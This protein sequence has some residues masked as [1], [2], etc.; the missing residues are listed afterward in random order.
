MESAPW[1]VPPG[2]TQS[3]EVIPPLS[4]TDDTRTW[5]GHS[6]VSESPKY[7][8]QVELPDMFLS[9]LFQP[10]EEGAL[11]DEALTDFSGSAS[12]GSDSGESPEAFQEFMLG[13][14]SDSSSPSLDTSDGP[15]MLSSPPEDVPAFKANASL[16]GMFGAWAA[17]GAGAGAAPAASD[18]P[19]APT[20]SMDHLFA[21]IFSLG[22]S[23]APL[24]PRSESSASAP[25]PSPAPQPTPEAAPTSAT[26]AAPSADLPALGMLQMPTGSN[27]NAHS[28]L[29]RIREFAKQVD[30]DTAPADRS[31]PRAG[32]TPRASASSAAESSAATS[33][34]SD[35]SAWSK[36]VAHNAI[37]RRYRSN[38]NDRIAGLRDVVPALREMRPRDGTRRRRRNK[39]EKQE[40]VDGVAAAT[41]MSKATVL[42][43]ATEYICYLKSRE[44]QL[45]RQVSALQMLVRSLEG[46]DELLAAWNAELARVDRLHPPAEAA[47]L[48]ARPSTASPADDEDEE[49]DEEDE[50]A[51]DGPR[52][53]M[54]RYLLGAFVGFSVVN[55]AA[56]WAAQE[57]PALAPSHTRVLHAGH[58]LLKRAGAAAPAPHTYDHVPTVHLV[59]ELLR[60]LALVALV[61]V[62]LC[63]AVVR[64]HRAAKH[65]RLKRAER[66]QEVCALPTLLQT[67][68]E[69][70]CAASAEPLDDARARYAALSRA[71]PAFDVRVPFVR[72]V[73]RGLVACALAHVPLLDR[74]VAWAI[75]HASDPT[76]QRLEKHVCL[77]RLTL[78]LALGRA[79]QPSNLQRLLTLATWQKHLLAAPH[80]D[81][82][83][84]LLAL[85]YA[86]LAP[87]SLLR[88]WLAYQ[89]AQLWNEARAVHVDAGAVRA[90]DR[91][92]AHAVLG[93]VLRLPLDVA[94][95]YALSHP[96]ART[97]ELTSVTEADTR[98]AWVCAAPLRN[99]LDAMRNEELLAFWTALLASL[100][101]GDD[102][103]R[104]APA[105]LRP[106][107]LDVVAD[108]ASRLG[109]RQRLATIAHARPV[110]NVLAAE[111]LAV[112]MA[113]LELVSGRLSRAQQCARALAAR[114][115][116]SNAAHAF[117]AL[118]QHTPSKQVAP[119]GPVDA[120]ASVVLHWLQLQRAHAT[121]E[122]PPAE[123]AA[124]VAKLQALASQCIWEVVSP[125]PTRRSVVRS[126]P[127][128]AV[129]QVQQLLADVFPPTAPA[130]PAVQLAQRDW[131][132]DTYAAHR[133]HIP[134]LTSSLD[135]LMD[136]LGSLVAEP[137]TAL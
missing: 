107:V 59:A 123:H 54:P 89:G 6:G 16:D 56:P 40:L 127:L 73:A 128:T 81:E 115:L 21:P 13:H 28:A 113:T 58:Q 22:G 26:P 98:G 100:M 135:T 2:T 60:T 55:R 8:A 91:R 49:E 76:V 38:I 19:P 96:A 122:A 93:D 79:V 109:L 120:L 41:K 65:R 131:H 42:S 116:R 20:V 87:H 10:S 3:M 36:K 51:A 125:T 52:R 103:A 83:R 24:W 99:I 84:V 66:L 133:A 53:K 74:A 88:P 32:A 14:T 132:R 70:A 111:Q 94:C 15:P 126:T 43:K 39:A 117:V 114:P 30:T 118:V 9:N 1:M 104:D 108:R 34:S 18:A 102:A 68:L 124:A 105:A 119:T 121:A 78:E 12:T 46:G 67:P 101:R 29:A 61:G 7:W 130:P 110:H 23:G 45:D 37:E 5:V 57:P 97:G 27:A 85:G 82:E 69:Q 95:T 72:V 47:G 137:P 112:A 80:T 50:D 86:S 35:G 136:R 62:L 134:S 129:E 44:V 77:Q 64:V 92:A 90:P 48:P 106:H 17:P 25:Q 75:R 4:A 33:P 71:L 63:A 31:A 11:R